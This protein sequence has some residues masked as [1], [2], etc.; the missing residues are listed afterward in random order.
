MHLR[1]DVRPTFAVRTQAVAVQYPEAV[2]VGWSA[3]HLWEHPWVPEGAE[4]HAASAMARRS[5]PGRRHTRLVPDASRIRE[6]DGLRASDP[7]A[8]A[9]ELCREASFVEAV[10][11]LDGL[12]RAQPGTCAELAVCAEEFPR[13]RFIRR[14]LEAVDAQ[15][16][17]REASWLRAQLVQAG[18]VGFRPGEHVRVEAGQ[19]QL[20]WSPLLVHRERRTAIVS[21]PAPQVPG[22]RV[23]SVPPAY[24]RCEASAVIAR[25]DE[26]LGSA[27]PTPTGGGDPATSGRDLHIRRNAR[28]RA[29]TLEASFWLG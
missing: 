16:P 17:S 23:I 14:V 22:W 27:T 10:I 4:P 24:A 28:S 7:V 29:T 26:V 3:A 12:E 21:G 2:L 25:V 20:V 6:V 19:E 9:A 5:L 18:I 11:A 1:R 15:S 13:T 8:T